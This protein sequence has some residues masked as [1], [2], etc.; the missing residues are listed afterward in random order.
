MNHRQISLFSRARESES[1]RKVRLGLSSRLLLAIRKYLLLIP[2]P[3]HK[4]RSH[5]S[6]I[7]SEQ[8]W[9]AKNLFRKASDTDRSRSSLEKTIFYPPHDRDGVSRAPRDDVPRRFIDQEVHGLSVFTC[10]A[11]PRSSTNA[12][13][14]PR[15]ERRCQGP[16][17]RYLSPAAVLSPYVTCLLRQYYH[18]NRTQ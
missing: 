8:P 16:K 1:S 4:W 14:T 7:F 12:I 6:Y 11:F 9:T 18:L 13:Y 15:P 3:S 17:V 5:T 10:F 2:P